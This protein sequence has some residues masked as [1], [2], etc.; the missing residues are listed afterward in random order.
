MKSPLSGL[1]P[2]EWEAL[3]DGCA[4]CCVV[5][6]EDEDTGEIFYTDVAC[7]YLDLDTGRCTDYANRSS[8]NPDCVTLSKKNLALM[9]IMPSTCAYRRTHERRRVVLD[10]KSLSVC[11]KVVSEDAIAERDLEDHIVDWISVDD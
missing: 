2:S 5:K 3:C 11:G 9:R 4:R 7:R 10:V 1:N 8:I 6:L